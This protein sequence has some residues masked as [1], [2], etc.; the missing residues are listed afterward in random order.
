MKLPFLDHAYCERST[1][2]QYFETKSTKRSMRP[3]LRTLGILILT[4]TISLSTYAQPPNDLCANV[5][6]QDLLVGGMLFLSGDNSGATSTDDGV[7][8]STIGDAGLPTVWHAFTLGSCAQV[9]VEYCGTT[10]SFGNYWNLISRDCPSSIEVNATAFNDVDCGDG[11]RTMIFDGLAAGTY[12]LPVLNDPFN[13]ADGPYEIKLSAIV[14]TGGTPPND[15]CGDVPV[16]T[17]IVGANIGFFGDNT[18]ATSTGDGVPGS[19]IG[20]A[21]LPTVWH[22]FYLSTCSKVIVEYCGTNPSFGNYWNLLSADCPST[23][24]YN[25]LSANDTD[26]SDGNRTLVYDGLMVGTYYL[27]VL[28]DPFNNAEGPY[29]IAVSAEICTGGTPPNDLCADVTPV[30]LQLGTTIDLFGDN[31]GA[32]STDDGQPGSIIGD[33]NLPTVWHAFTTSTCSNVRVSYCGTS[34]RFDN[35][36]NLLSIDCPSSMSINPSDI[37]DTLCSDGNR[38]LLYNNLPAGTYYIPVLNDAFNSAE[39][40]YLIQVSAMSCAGA[41]PVNDLCGDVT[42]V[43]LTIM[44][45]VNFSGNNTGATAIGDG[46]PGSIIGDAGLATVWHAFTLNSCAAVMVAFCNTD[47][48]FG[49]Y[50][51]LL[52]T[53]CPANA[54]VFADQVNDLDCLDG[55]RTMYYDSLVAGTYY[56]PVLSDPFNQAEGPY[57]IE[58]SAHPCGFFNSIEFIDKEHWS[59]Y[60]NPNN[61]TINM[62]STRNGVHTIEVIDLRGGLVYQKET[63]I[64]AGHKIKLDLQDMLTSGIYILKIS[65]AEGSY[66]QKLIVE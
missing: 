13:N 52:D 42:P 33:S 28:T 11:N 46:V 60:P 12:Y 9:L 66:V 5:Q 47:P 4:C 19:I 27:P 37:S 35:Y 59:V 49:N 22:S 21:N 40:P 26:C 31:T 32:T 25:P 2:R 7:P 38:T 51:D 43:A 56:L 29:Q 53:L 57:E 48:A 23:S 14:C 10:P 36:W 64:I 54:T 44:T 1:K 65:N 62:V 24:S 8:G 39:G 6:A 15:L 55:N 61:G 34:P 58:V 30:D 17:L 50:W 18:G 16:D 3:L 45:P 63:Q 20:D 41:A